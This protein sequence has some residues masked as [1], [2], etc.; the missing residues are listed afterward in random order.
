MRNERK[1]T[2][3]FS[4]LQKAKLCNFSYQN[5][6]AKVHLFSK[7]RDDTET[8]LFCSIELCAFENSN[9]CIASL[10]TNV[11]LCAFDLYKHNHRIHPRTHL[12]YSALS[13]RLEL[14]LFSTGN[15]LP[16]FQVQRNHLTHKANTTH[17]KVQQVHNIIFKQA[18]T[19]IR[20][21]ATF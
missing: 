15:F 5:F 13:H 14:I 10:K 8:S 21:T 4:P 16:V 20:R 18:S 9:T 7:V 2:Y 3:S 19:Y 12:F 1:D 11:N 17:T 6:Q